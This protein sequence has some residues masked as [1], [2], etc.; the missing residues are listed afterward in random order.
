MSKT[1]A[2]FSISFD[3]IS[4]DRSLNYDIYVNSSIV[5]GKEKFVRVATKGSELE[6]T[7]V[8]EYRNKYPQMYL[9]EQ[10]RQAFVRSVS[11]VEGIGDTQ[12]TEVIKDSAIKYLDNMFNSGKDISAERLAENLK[13]CKEA[14]D[15]MVEVIH[16]YSIDSL[17]SLIGDLSFHDFYT[18]DHSINVCMYSMTL[19]RTLKP[20]ASKNELVHVGLGGLLHD[21]GKIKVSTEILNKPGRLTEDEY[22]EIKKH[23]DS[24]LELLLNEKIEIDEGMD[25]NIIGR[26]INEHHESWDGSGYPKGLKKKEIHVFA[27]VCAIADFFDAITTKRSYA[28]VMPISK[29][30]A[31]MKKTAGTKI[32]PLIFK[33]FE[34]SIDHTP[35]EGATNYKLAD[36]FDPTLFYEE[37][38]L[39]EIE[40]LR[41]EGTFGKIKILE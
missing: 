32:D 18:F 30:I 33:I 5:K 35:V 27:R 23:P 22:N 41:K 2:Y 4:I 6:A 38:P 15:S 16:D 29:A 39:E 26:V 7:D 25:L 3:L 9:S 13:Y 36:H 19:Y 28:D 21:L 20:E 37:L 31:V 34:K 12:K 17:R 11:Q 40:E 1:E 10:D 24:G 14:V 8:E